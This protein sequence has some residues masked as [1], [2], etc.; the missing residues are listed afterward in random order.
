M[1]ADN[2]RGRNRPVNKVNITPVADRATVECAVC[3][4]DIIGNGYQNRI[5][6]GTS[7]FYHVDYILKTLTL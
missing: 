7:H 5:F 2:L 6:F 4:P 3:F 1:T